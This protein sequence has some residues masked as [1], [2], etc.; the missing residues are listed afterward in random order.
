[1]WYDPQSFDFR[2]LCCFRSAVFVRLCCPRFSTVMTLSPIVL[3][4]VRVGLCGSSGCSSAGLI[5][6]RVEQ[7]LD[8]P[9]EAEV[10]TVAAKVFIVQN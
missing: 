3:T 5:V 7:S 9:A 4:K 1:M 8:P 6:L 2:L 10:P